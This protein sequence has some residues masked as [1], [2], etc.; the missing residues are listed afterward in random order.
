MMADLEQQAAGIGA[1]A[2]GV[3]RRLYDYV[4]TQTEPVGRDEAAE[5]LGLPRHQAKFHLDRLEEAGLLVSDYLRLTGRTGPGAGRPAKVYRRAPEEISVSLPP[6]AYLL[7]G[8]LMACAISRSSETGAPV[9]DALT[10]VARERGREM[11]RTATRDG[12]ALDRAREALAPH[13]Y[14]PRIEDECLAMTNCPFHVLMSEHTALVCG[15][16]HD[17]LGGFCEGVGGLRASLEP[18]EGRC[19]VVLRAEWKA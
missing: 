6:R 1:L 7:A 9:A 13:G 14:E 17:L 11:S 15:L 16:N 18:A 19:C 10:D 4:C 12:V 8:E 2:D 5:A 3:R